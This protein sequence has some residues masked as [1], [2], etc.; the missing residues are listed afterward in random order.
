[1]PFMLIMVYVICM[2]MIQAQL[3]Y[4][5]RKICGQSLNFFLGRYEIFEDHYTNQCMDICTCFSS[6]ISNNDFRLRL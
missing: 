3:M 5:A 6:I 2:I 1:M 4:V